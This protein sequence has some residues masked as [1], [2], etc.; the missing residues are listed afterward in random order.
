[1]NEEQLLHQLREIKAQKRA[2]YARHDLDEALRLAA[3]VGELTAQL[4]RLRREAQR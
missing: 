2:A 1:M 4:W 3:L